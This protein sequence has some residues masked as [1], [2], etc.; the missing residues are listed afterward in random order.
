[1]F[2]TNSNRSLIICVVA[3]AVCVIGFFAT[4]N[5]IEAPIV[6]TKE[7]GVY[8]H[9]IDVGQ[10]DCTLIQTS[11]GNIL[12]DAG[13]PESRNAIIKYIDELEITEFEYA[14]FTHP[15]SDHIGSAAALLKR[16]D[17]NNIVLPDAVST[18][19]FYEKLLDA[20]EKEECSV[21]LGE[22]EKSFALGDVKIDLFAPRS[23][24]Y[25][26][27]LN[28][29]SIVAKLIYKETSF[30]FTGDAEDFSEHQMLKHGCDVD[31]DVL[32][33][34]HHGSSTSSC[35]EFLNAVFPSVA[36]VS[37]GEDNEYGHPHREVVERLKNIEAQMYIT[38]ESGD[39]VVFS[40]GKTVNVSTEK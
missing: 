23:Y 25:P 6:D 27:D 21:I 36:I 32:K 34:G 38:Y 3:I 5:Y 22:A 30:L 40:D 12:I 33:V 26:D 37:A 16:Y 18:T 24:Y 39:I 4:D 13:M 10:G 35:E 7:D 31:A 19:V 20:I 29:M 2:N 8:V 14:I 28:D 9:F 15:H 11:Y 1:M 17:F